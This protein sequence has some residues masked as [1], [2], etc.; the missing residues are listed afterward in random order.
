VLVGLRSKTS[1]AFGVNPG[2]SAVA[3]SIHV[4]NLK[5][6]RITEL[7]GSEGMW[8]PRWSPDGQFIAG[9]SG[10]NVSKLVLYN[11][12]TR[13]QT[14]LYIGSGWPS[15]SE[16]GEFLFFRLQYRTEVWRVRIRDRKA[17]RI[18]N[19][20]DVRAAWFAVG[21]NNSL[22]TARDAGTEEI[23]ALDWEAP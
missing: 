16:D 20:N 18:T 5:T 15:W 2:S 9:L 12:R 23:Y 4:V 3:K 21:P 19:L 7:P 11:L 10:F 17:E 1:L 13:R 22:I 6:N 14:Q 8:S